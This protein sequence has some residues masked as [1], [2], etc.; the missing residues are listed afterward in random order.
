MADIQLKS[1]DTVEIAAAISVNI[2]IFEGN[3]S[4]VPFEER[5]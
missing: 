3:R 1:D 2:T 5:Y 4:D